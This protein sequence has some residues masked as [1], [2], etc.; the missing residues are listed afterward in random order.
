MFRKL[1]QLSSKRI[2]FYST[3]AELDPHLK[4]A[5]N[6]NEYKP[7]K[8]PGK[9]RVKV[10]AIPPDI[11][12]AIEIVVNDT[13]AKAYYQDSVD[14]SNYLRSRLLP[15]EEDDIDN[16]ARKIHNSVS[17]K[18]K[19]RELEKLTE[20]QQKQCKDYVN[21]KVFNLL[22]KNV[23]GWANISYNKATCLQ[24]LMARAAPEYAVLV[25][26]LDDIKK[27]LP[28]YKPR[29]FFDFG[30]GIGTGT[31]AINHYWKKDIFEY[32]CVDTSSEMHEL[33]RLLLCG[34]RENVEL[35]YR[36]YFQRQFLPASSNVKYNIVLSAYSLFELP[37]QKSR[38]ET[39][40]KLWNKTED[41]L[42]VVE[43]GSR[44]GFHI[45]NEARDFILN[46]PKTNKKSVGHVFSPCPNDNVCPRYLEQDTPC[47]FLMQYESLP[48][49]KKPQVYPDLFTYVILRKGE[50]PADDPQWPRLVRPPL[51]RSGHTICRLCT[52]QGELKEVIFTKSKHD[53]STYRCA[54]SSNWGEELPVKIDS[55]PN[56]GEIVNTVTE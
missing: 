27:K 50:R 40:Q 41:F 20:I 36:A 43:Q 52:A 23:Y 25:R 17:T 32:F 28:D 35:R 6:S 53:Q 54:R 48:L 46:F 5:F 38:L 16:K 31:W 34:G 18:F 9:L 30:S 55:S 22:K 56:D 13:N 7:R 8:H 12:K 42:I 2:R 24:Y 45:V 19:P 37:D 1:Y 29:S 44:A 21:V 11:Q 10:V 15:P 47:N 33:A 39:I 14:L 3:K 49:V 4:D 51:V 26:I